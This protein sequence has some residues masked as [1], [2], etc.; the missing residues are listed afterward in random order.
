[1]PATKKTLCC[2]S[3]A[4]L[5]ISQREKMMNAERVNRPLTREEAWAIAKAY[6]KHPAHLAPALNALMTIARGTPESAE[7][8]GA[9]DDKLWAE[10]GIFLQEELTSGQRPI[11]SLWYFSNRSPLKG[12]RGWAKGEFDRAMRLAEQQ[13]HSNQE[14]IA[15]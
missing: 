6:A 3:I 12:M 5:V 4:G 7:V 1:M 13:A 14:Q 11:G 10:V 9:Q 2:A 8:A 15:A